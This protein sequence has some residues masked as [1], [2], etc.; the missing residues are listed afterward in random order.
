MTAP[1]VTIEEVKSYLPI[2]SGNFDYDERLAALVATA[3][4]QIETATNRQFE[5]KTYVEHFST[6]QTQ[7]LF[8]DFTGPSNDTGIL[9]S[10]RTQRFN[11]RG[12]PI[13]ADQPREVRYDPSQAFG[14]DTIVPSDEWLINFQT[15]SLILRSET[16]S[17]EA[18]L[19]V[20]YVAGYQV[21]ADGTLSYTLPADLKL[22]CIV[23]T[24]HMFN[25]LT[26]DNIGVDASRGEGATATARWTSRLGLTP[27]VAGMVR[28][29]KALQVGRG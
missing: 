25:R 11:L 15:G 27:E 8:Y 17:H 6:V 29:Y 13:I 28:H 1:F 19:R 22:A 14:T 2:R 10:P 18:A 16:G 26:P 21:G 3:S 23:Q 12:F 9:S 4:Q 24:V 20:S 5:R 7:R